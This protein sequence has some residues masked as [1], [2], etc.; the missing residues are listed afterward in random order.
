MYNIYI[1]THIR[2]VC[3]QLYT[4][5]SSPSSNY[6]PTMAK[7]AARHPPKY[8]SIY[9]YGRPE[10]FKLITGCKEDARP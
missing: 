2:T 7:Y 4:F 1:H 8:G 10:I 5:L 3:A 6:M 9:I